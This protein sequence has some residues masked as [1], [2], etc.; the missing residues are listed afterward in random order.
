VES[1]VLTKPQTVFVGAGRGPV[2]GP[3]W[4]EGCWDV[5]PALVDVAFPL[6]KQFLRKSTPGVTK[7]SV[8]EAADIGKST[9]QDPVRQQMRW[10]AQ[11]S[12][13]EEGLSTVPDVIFNIT[14]S[15]NALLGTDANTSVQMQ[16][17]KRLS[18]TFATP[19]RSAMAVDGGGGQGQETDP[20]KLELFLNYSTY[21]YDKDDE[22]IFRTDRLI[23]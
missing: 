7:A 8:A 1:P 21:K 14:S 18:V 15:M 4:L 2:T 5:S 22:D 12:P 16:N 17:P 11:S 19:R 6:G 20:R 23:R 9:P 13:N 3:S 10:T